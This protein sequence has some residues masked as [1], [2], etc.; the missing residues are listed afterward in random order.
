MFEEVWC[1]GFQELAMVREDESS[2]QQKVV[3]E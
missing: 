2:S 1:Y 3:D